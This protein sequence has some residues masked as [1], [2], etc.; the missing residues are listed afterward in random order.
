MKNLLLF[1]C[2]LPL[3]AS[4]RSVPA[5]S[6]VAGKKGKKIQLEGYAQLGYINEL[7]IISRNLPSNAVSSLS[8][9]GTGGSIGIG[10]TSKTTQKRPLG[11]GLSFDYLGYAMDDALVTNERSQSKFAFGKLTPAVYLLFKTKPSFNFHLCANASIMLPMHRN[12]NNYF[13]YGLKA[14]LGVGAFVLDLGFSTAQVGSGSPSTLISPTHWSEQMLYAGIICY[15]SRLYGWNSF[16]SKLKKE[17][18]H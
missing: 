9:P 18:K 2:L 7:W 6:V 4:A 3:M 1:I 17:L 5:D 13:N 11:F 12:Q 14:C 15:P 8:Y 10:F 16:K